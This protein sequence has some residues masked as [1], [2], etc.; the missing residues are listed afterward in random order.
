M[1]TAISTYRQRTTTTTTAKTR[2]L[3]CCTQ[4]TTT[5]RC[6]IKRISIIT[7]RVCAHAGVLRC[8]QSQPPQTHEAQAI[9]TQ[10]AA[11]AAAAL[12]HMRPLCFCVYV[13]FVCTRLVV[14]VG[15]HFILI[16][17]TE[18]NR[19]QNSRPAMCIICTRMMCNHVSV[20]T[21]TPNSYA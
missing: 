18:E 7:H 6:T 14:V 4:A 12:L 8:A 17:R 20:L 16:D 9:I 15:I 10:V 21:C 1:C 5:R 13:C 11:A 2:H 3:M 19:T